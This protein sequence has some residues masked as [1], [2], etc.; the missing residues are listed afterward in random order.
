MPTSESL[1]IAVIPRSAKSA[2]VSFAAAMYGLPYSAISMYAYRL[3]Y[4]TRP[5]TQPTKH[6]AQ[7]ANTTPTT[8]APGSV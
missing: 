6:S 1:T 2:H 3:K 5:S 8:A 4:S 7:H